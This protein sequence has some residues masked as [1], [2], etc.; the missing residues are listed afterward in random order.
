[1]SIIKETDMKIIRAILI[2]TLFTFTLSGF[3]LADTAPTL[4][5]DPVGGAI[6]GGGAIGTARGATGN[7][8][9]TPGGTSPT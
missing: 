5:L 7:S 9:A 8:R 2:A 3:A 1:V 4:T 6:T